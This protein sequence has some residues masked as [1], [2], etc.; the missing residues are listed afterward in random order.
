MNLATTAA[1]DA[2][3]LTG[4]LAAK[5][6]PVWGTYAEVAPTTVASCSSGRSKIRVTVVIVGYR[7]GG[8]RCRPLDRRENE[9]GGGDPVARVHARNQGGAAAA[10]SRLRPT[11]LWDGRNSGT[12]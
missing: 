1:R 8:I 10:D 2:C 12:S 7:Q 5:H 4:T 9:H 11:P 6:P 3:M